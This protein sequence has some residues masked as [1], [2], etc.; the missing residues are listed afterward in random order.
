MQ[1]CYKLI[2]SVQ[3][4]FPK[5]A[6]VLP[7]IKRIRTAQK[8]LNSHLTEIIP[9]CY[10]QDCETGWFEYRTFL[11]YMLTK[12]GLLDIVDDV[13]T[14]EPVILAVTFDGGKIR[15]FFSHVTGGFKLVNKRC[16]NPRTGKLLFSETGIEGAKPCPLFPTQSCFH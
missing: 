16:I 4:D 2:Y 1:E 10:A 11:D 15:R 7:E 13:N 8:Q 14:T 6:K 3:K 5:W 12:T 9:I